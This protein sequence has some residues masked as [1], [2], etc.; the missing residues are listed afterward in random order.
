MMFIRTRQSR[1]PMWRA[2]LLASLLMLLGGLLGAW[3]NADGGVM[4]FGP[5]IHAWP[6]NGKAA[7]TPRPVPYAQARVLAVPRAKAVTI[8]RVDPEI[9]LSQSWESSIVAVEHDPSTS[10]D[11]EVV[12]TWMLGLSAPPLTDTRIGLATSRN[13]GATWTRGELAPPPNATNIQFDPMST[14]NPLTGRIH[15]AAMSRHFTTANQNALWIADKA[16]GAQAFAPSRTLR[17]ATA[18]DKGWMAAGPLPNG[19]AGSAVYMVYNGPALPGTSGLSGVAQISVDDGQSFSSPVLISGPG[20]IGHH[21]RVD[22]QGVLSVTYYDNGIGKFVRGRGALDGFDAPVTVAPFAATPQAFQI[23]VAG[24]FRIPYFLMHAI[25]PRNGRIYVVYN[26]VTGFPGGEADVDLLMRDSRDG[27]ATWS[28]IR[29]ISEDPARPA[30]QYL[31]WLEVDDTGTLHLAYYDTG[32]TTGNDSGIQALVDVYYASSSD[33]GQS[34]VTQRLTDTP[35]DS[36]RTSWSPGGFASQFVGDRH[37]GDV[38]SGL[39][40]VPGGRIRWCGDER[41]EG[42]PRTCRHRHRRWPYRHLAELRREWAW[43]ADRGPRRQ[44][45]ARVVVH[46][47]ARWRASVVRRHRHVCRAGRDDSDGA[48]GRRTIPAAVQSERHQSRAT[49]HDDDHVRELPACAGRLQL[50][51]RLRQRQLDDGSADRA[52]G[53]HVFVMTPRVSAMWMPQIPLHRSAA[54]SDRR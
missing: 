36:T 52:E 20:A 4:G 53:P 32:R 37:V 9:P 43:H 19:Q 26:D 33:E 38:E 2:A 51:A 48:C 47:P 49:R 41:G 44:P 46:I 10:S 29:N 8:R 22:A 7:V 27:G 16:S 35:L 18:T 3:L 5:T 13:G 39:Y 28:A 14:V 11:D 31:P 30:D 23:A 40:R 34:W 1:T 21:P 45:D 42:G 25:D 24:E 54:R 6:A 12:V 50:R 15:L 17:P